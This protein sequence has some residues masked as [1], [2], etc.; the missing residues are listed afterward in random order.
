MKIVA[1]FYANLGN[2][3]LKNRNV[4]VFF[5]L[6]HFKEIR[7]TISSFYFFS[8]KRG[9]ISAISLWISS[10]CFFT[11]ILQIYN[12]RFVAVSSRIEDLR[13]IIIAKF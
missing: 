8:F 11:F 10:L 5:F 12:F 7:P 4:F 9:S 13:F 3:F 2:S 6:V 1:F